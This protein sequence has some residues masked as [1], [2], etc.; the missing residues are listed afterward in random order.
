[1]NMWKQI[2]LMIVAL[3][4]L[5]ALDW[6]LTSWRNTSSEGSVAPAPFV[7]AEVFADRPVAAVKLETANH[8]LLYVFHDGL[9]RCIGFNS[10]PAIGSRVSALTPALVA[11]Y[12]VVRSR[13]AEDA[14]AYGF[15]ETKSFRLKF[16]G[17]YVLQDREG[18]VIQE[19]EVGKSI[20]P[21][22]S[23]GC[24]ARHVG[25]DDVWAIDVDFRAIIGGCMSSAASRCAPTIQP[26]SRWPAPRWWSP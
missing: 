13:D 18:D 14:A 9:W 15:N 21:T 22:G 25:S 20:G 5:I 19:I 7:S 10:A 17:Q 11:A 8:Q 23:G 1:M 4:A 12:G 24:F 3:A 16:C 6:Q 26:G 2:I